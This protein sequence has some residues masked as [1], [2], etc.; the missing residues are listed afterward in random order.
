M[1]FTWLA[2]L[3]QALKRKIPMEHLLPLGTSNV[4]DRFGLTGKKGRIRPGADADLVILRLDETTYADQPSFRFRNAFSPY[5]GMTFELR[6]KK[7]ILRG[8]IIY[9][10]QTGP[11]TEKYGRCLGREDYGSIS[12]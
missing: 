2:F 8:N 10:D 4:A 11:I 1:Q 3:D 12:S 5:E 7:T 9:D 6:I